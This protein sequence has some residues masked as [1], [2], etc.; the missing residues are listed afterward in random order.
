MQHEWWSIGSFLLQK[1]F[2]QTQVNNYVGTVQKQNEWLNLPYFVLQLYK[3][4]QFL[5]LKISII[6][7]GIFDITELSFTQLGDLTYNNTFR[8]GDLAKRVM[9]GLKM[10]GLNSMEL[11]NTTHKQCHCKI[12]QLIINEIGNNVIKH[13][14][15]LNWPKHIL[16]IIWKLLPPKLILSY[17]TK[18]FKYKIT[19]V[20]HYRMNAWRQHH[21]IEVDLHINVASPP[22]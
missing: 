10:D 11:I 8:G 20:K 15:K 6:H 7:W 4:N 3:N 9:E 5:G 2:N 12:K 18:I 22:R 16:H 19:S 21:T 14:L 1:K 13:G 17:L